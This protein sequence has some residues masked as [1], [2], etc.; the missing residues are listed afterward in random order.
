M[1][2]MIPCTVKASTPSA[3]FTPFELA[4]IALSPVV[5]L[6]LKDMAG[7]VATDASG[8]GRN[9]TYGSGV[10]LNGASLF[11]NGQ[12]AA[13][14]NYG[15]I[16]VPRGTWAE[17]AGDYTAM[18]AAAVYG[19]SGPTGSFPKVCDKFVSSSNGYATYMIQVDLGNGRPTGRLSTSA[20]NYN[21]ATYL[22]NVMDGTPRLYFLRRS[23]TEL[24]L[25]SNGTKV[26]TATVSGTNQ[27]STG[28]DIVIGGTGGVDGIDE[29]VQWFGLWG[30][31][32][33]D[34]QI[35][36]LT[37]LANTPL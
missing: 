21:D 4:V 36:D 11:P 9:G 25:W 24:S 7:T 22:M 19:P 16:T 18:I 5:F 26:A 17:P 33:S 14:T 37:T 23:G 6:P 32:L 8:N 20:N 30:S 31:A 15:L 3:P 1:F 13:R 27:T 34:T 10:T 28:S 35:T 12:R 29:S 2:T